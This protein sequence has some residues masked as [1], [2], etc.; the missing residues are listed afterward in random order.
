MAEVT[1][2]RVARAVSLAVRLAAALI[3]GAMALAAF[4]HYGR[5]SPSDSPLEDPIYYPF[6]IINA[7]GIAWFAWY[8]AALVTSLWDSP[9]GEDMYPD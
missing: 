5:L 1:R 2:S 6:S 9:R 7:A 8:L 3:A 4:L